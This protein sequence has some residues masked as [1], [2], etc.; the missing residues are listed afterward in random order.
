MLALARFDMVVDHSTT[1][2]VGILEFVVFVVTVIEQFSEPVAPPAAPLPPIEVVASADRVPPA[3]A[4][5]SLALEA[6]EAPPLPSALPPTLDEQPRPA[7]HPRQ[8]Q[9]TNAVDTRGIGNAPLPVPPASSATNR[10]IDV[11]WL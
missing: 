8:A 9:S 6:L 11:S 7:K 5:P 10:A 3:L 1:P 2:T 4:S